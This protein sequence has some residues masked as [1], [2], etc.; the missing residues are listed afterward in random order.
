[1]NLSSWRK[2]GQIQTTMRT[3]KLIPN[4]VCPSLLF[5]SYLLYNGHDFL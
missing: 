2:T 1:M 5:A 4:F 3:K